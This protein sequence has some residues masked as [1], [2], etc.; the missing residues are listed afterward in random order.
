MGMGILSHSGFLVFFIN[1]QLQGHNPIILLHRLLLSPHKC[2][3]VHLLVDV[4]H[5]LYFFQNSIYLFI[6][7]DGEGGGVHLWP[8]ARFKTG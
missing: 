6:L 8:G 3:F 4:V 2:P 7:H 1:N 5:L